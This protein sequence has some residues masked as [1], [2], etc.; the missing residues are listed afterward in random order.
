MRK[1]W[2]RLIPVALVLAVG[3]VLAAC[4]QATPAATDTGAQGGP[5]TMNAISKNFTL[6]PAQAD[7]ADSQ[8][9]D[10]YIYE[11]LITTDSSGKTTAQLA[12]SWTV[13]EDNLAYTFELRNDIQ[14]SDGTFVNADAVV[15]AF[16]RW[17]DP[18]DPAHGTG[19]YKTWL[20]VFG[21]FK[22]ETTS[23]GKKK[24]AFDGAEKTG[25]F[26]V[27]LHLNRPV[28]KFLDKLS[29]IQFAISKASADGKSFV[30]TNVYMVGTNNAQH[31]VLIAN[32]KYTGSNPATGDLDFP[33]K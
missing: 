6:D 20:D 10:S 13:A 8:T 32:P 12:K 22:G 26:T 19:A 1:D 28:D 18:A 30:G 15:A 3:V 23:D 16:T 4:Q 5:Q 21:G 17:F 7:D 14:F 33:L 9:V 11:T 24:S 29:T 27:V 25:D 2:Q 31:L